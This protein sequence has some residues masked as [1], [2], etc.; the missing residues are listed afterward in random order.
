MQILYAQ[1]KEKLFTVSGGMSVLSRQDL[2]Y[3]PFVHE[4]VSNHSYRLRY[5]QT[6]R[7][8]QFAEVGF[9]YNASQLAEPTEMDMGD[10]AHMILP[11]EFLHVS[12]TY[13]IGKA[14]QPNTR[15]LAWIGGALQ[16]DMQAG[17]FSF[18]L[19]NMFGYFINQSA[20]IWYRRAYTFKDKHQLSVQVALPI[21][22]WLARPPYLA[23]DDEFI[24]NISSHDNAKIIMAF[25]GDG[26]LATWN[27][28]QRL[29]LAAEY[30]YPI[31]KHILIGTEY[32]FDF[33]HTN[34]PRTLLS[35]Q[36]QLNISATIKF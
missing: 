25:I 14:I 18:A 11:H 7:Y 24:E 31:S 17:Y 35:Y 36:H 3:S 30:K 13:G 4:D 1:Q 15:Y 29:N 34:I 23:E 22:S 32:R 2:V 10:H 28:L 5:Q 26:Q 9:T 19:S 6:G 21:L 12:L 33:I 20:Q 27:R 8:F 16:V